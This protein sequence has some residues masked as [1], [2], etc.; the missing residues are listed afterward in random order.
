MRH[1]LAGENLASMVP[2]RVEHI[3]TW[4]HAFVTVGISEHVVVSLKTTDY[5]FPLYLYPTTDCDDLFAQRESSERQPNLSPKLVEALEEAHGQVPSPEDIFHYTYAILHTPAYR[6]KY[7]EFLRI[8]FPR[9]P[10]TKDSALFA[11]LAELGARLVGLHLLT[12]PELDPPA[13]RFDG[14]GDS[15]VARTKAQGFRYD[16]DE[17]RMYVNKTQYFGPIPP[18]VHAYRIGGYQVCDKWLKDRKDRRL[19]LDDIRTYCRMVTAI[20]LTLAIQQELDMV[21]ENVDNSLMSVEAERSP[22]GA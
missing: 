13:C 6:E 9:I 5:H 18:E 20:G 4:Q 11:E 2:K 7:A 22:K 16:A 3:G 1:M 10:F 21:Y 15:L 12:S 14:E 8:D 19:A 17:Q